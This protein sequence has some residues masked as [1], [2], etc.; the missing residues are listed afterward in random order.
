MC[1]LISTVAVIA[2]LT[3]FNNRAN[4][5]EHITRSL[6]IAT[7]L[8]NERINRFLAP[9]YEQSQIN[10][11][12]FYDRFVER[13]ARAD[14][15]RYWL[16]GL[17]AYP[18]LEYLSVGIET[19]G[20]YFHVTRSGVDGL[21]IRELLRNPESGKLGFRDYRPE[22]YP[23]KFYFE[24]AEHEAGDPRA[25]PWYEKAKSAQDSVWTDAYVFL[26]SSGEP[27]TPGFTYATPFYDDAKELIGVMTV[28]F[29]LTTL[30]NFLKSLEGPNS[31]FFF[32]VEIRDDAPDRVIAHPDR[33]AIMRELP[34]QQAQFELVPESEIEDP[35]MAGFLN[36]LPDEM[37]DISDTLSGPLR[38][39]IGGVEYLASYMRLADQKGPRWVICW[40]VEEDQVMGH[41]HRNNM[42]LIYTGTASLLI[43]ALM[44]LILSARISKPL[45]SLAEESARVGQGDLE[46]IPN[47]GSFILEIDR[48]YS[49]T[50]EM[51]SGLRSFQKYVP[52]E[53][54]NA[55]LS[56]GEEARLGGE[57]KRLTIFF[58]D[59]EGFTA[60]S[61]KLTPEKVVGLL[62]EVHEVLSECVLAQG[63]TID[64]FIGDAL[65]AFWGAPNPCDDHALRAC[66]AAI[67][68][69]RQLAAQREIWIREGHPPM[70]CRIG[71]H[72]SEVVVGN[73]G[74]QSR[75][76]YTVI[77][78]GVNLCS[79]LEG[80]NKVYGTRILI[81][82]ETWNS[83]SS[84]FIARPVDRVSV[85]GKNQSVLL[86]ELIDSK[87]N[88]TPETLERVALHT[89]ALESY[90]A[91][92]W[93]AAIHLLNQILT[94]QPEDG[95][96]TVLLSRA[97]DFERNPPSEDWDGVTRFEVK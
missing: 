24:D 19:N 57:R 92:D 20:E 52:Q 84:Q 6:N 82:E 45:K 17:Q 77:G 39:W 13:P 80:L 76:D 63:G 25:R 27:D 65:M 78:D 4:T 40:A 73:M 75:L 68:C 41:I 42:I 34:N 54:V 15:F 11:N 3:F 49:A 70:N 69:Q 30:C 29:A 31:G 94:T 46:P 44:A 10:H 97:L 23:E 67:R 95:P 26:G 22:E 7:Q 58:S 71:V 60:L 21:A 62:T 1:L 87:D 33:A 38:F 16:A 18:Q 48:L 59:L 91:R 51:K 43:A 37:S 74:A 56:S 36:F 53:L 2:L 14:V 90:F 8:I 12:L 55:L 64:K 81:S 35:I 66:Q 88:A 86:Y 96:A 93:Q 61:E 50:E 85:K 28:D 72:T 89:R 47:R 32:I 5:L 79:R 9:A 83:V